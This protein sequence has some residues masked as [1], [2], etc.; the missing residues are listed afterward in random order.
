M[1]SK[2]VLVVAAQLCVGM[3]GSPPAN[4]ALYL[5]EINAAYSSSPSSITGSFTL[6]D[7]IGPASI[8]NVDIH[9]TLPLI[10]GPFNFNFDQVVNPVDTWAVGYLWFAN[11]AFGA[12][13]THFFMFIN[14]DTVSNDGSYLIG[15]GFNAHQS[16][17]SVIGVNNWQDI[18][19]RM[20]REVASAVPEPSTWAMM[21]LGFGGLGFM[22]YL[23][24]RSSMID[25]RSSTV[26][27][28]VGRH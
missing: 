27:L 28:R 5:Y 9:A 26:L 24:R 21:L 10:G 23:R 4:A 15:M 25:I 16:E 6:D 8:S 13:D 2:L 3:A 12:G 11:H 18:E 22:A 14:Y 17:I 20:T 1:R 19:G 7:G